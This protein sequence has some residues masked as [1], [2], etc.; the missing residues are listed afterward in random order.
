MRNFYL[1]TKGQTVSAL[2]KNIN[3]T[4]F[5]IC[6]ILHIEKCRRNII[7]LKVIKQNSV[8]KYISLK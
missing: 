8:V 5:N 4:Y 3:I 7:L 2:L 6:E 1:L